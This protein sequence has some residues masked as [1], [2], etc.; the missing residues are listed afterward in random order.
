MAFSIAGPWSLF[1]LQIWGQWQVRQVSKNGL[2]GQ[3]DC[4]PPS[5]CLVVLLSCR[6]VVLLEDNLFQLLTKE[7]FR[8]LPLVTTGA[9]YPPVV[10]M[11][12][13]YYRSILC[14][15]TFC[16]L[17]RWSLRSAGEGS[18]QL[19][20]SPPTKLK[21]KRIL[22]RYCVYSHC[23]NLVI[24]LVVW[25]DLNLSSCRAPAPCWQA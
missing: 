2:Y 12:D 13:F 3:A 5:C 19:P 1:F 25:P 23:Y 20:R 8:M 22:L 6:L 15:N 24:W 9:Y 7:D 14:D 17:V 18:H 4:K 10:T 16:A 21:K 11:E